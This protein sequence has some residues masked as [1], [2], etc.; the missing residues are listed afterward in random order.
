MNIRYSVAAFL[1]LVY[2]ILSAQ[3]RAP[4]LD[5]LKITFDANTRAVQVNYDVWDP[6]DEI[7]EVNLQVCGGIG[8]EPC[9]TPQT[10][11]GDFGRVTRGKNKTIRWVFEKVPTQSDSLIISLLADDKHPIDIQELVKQVDSVRLKQYLLQI[12]GLRN[13]E[14]KKGNERLLKVRQYLESTFS[15]EGL[16]TVQVPFTFAEFKGSN[17]VTTLR[18]VSAPQKTLILCAHYDAVPTSVGANANASGVAGL[19]EAMHILGQYRFRNSIVGLGTDLSYYEFRGSNEYVWHGGLKPYQKVLGAI[20]L[21]A[22]GVYNDKPNTHPISAEIGKQIPEAYKDIAADQFRAN[23]VACIANERSESLAQIFLKSAATYSPNLRTVKMSTPDYGES[24]FYLQ[25]SDHITF[26]YRKDPALYIT[27]GGMSRDSRNNS[28]KD[29]PER[30]NM[31]FMSKVVATSMATLATLA[32][33]CHC[34]VLEQKIAL[35]NKH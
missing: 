1:C 33:P 35:P 24:T 32:D 5:N 10:L 16:P 17:I 25:D 21:D 26:W 2:P 29:T 15:A 34:D 7:L 12:Y 14:S 30:L 13:H 4:K 18:G 22:I 11:E 6:E 20:S 31:D 9:A 8:L 3:N 19:L 28:D 27:D 23:F